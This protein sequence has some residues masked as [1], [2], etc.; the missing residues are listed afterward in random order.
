MFIFWDSVLRMHIYVY[1]SVSSAK[2]LR[3]TQ[4]SVRIKVA[5]ADVF[6][7]VLVTSFVQVHAMVICLKPGKTMSVLTDLMMS[8]DSSVLE[9][10]TPD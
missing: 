5:D 9:H 8:G 7:T 2:T 4:Y 10:V 3:F 1:V 6:P